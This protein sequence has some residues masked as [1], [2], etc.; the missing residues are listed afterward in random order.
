MAIPDAR[1]RAWLQCRRLLENRGRVKISR[2]YVTHV[3][4]LIVP[5]SIYVDGHSGEV[6]NAV[7]KGC[8]VIDN[9]KRAEMLENIHENQMQIKQ[10]LEDTSVGSAESLGDI[11]DVRG[12]LRTKHVD[13]A[14]LTH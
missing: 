13:P 3:S 6:K 4:Y 2:K 9:E 11:L 12:S 10:S 1:C 5:Q 14:N 7:L 8:L